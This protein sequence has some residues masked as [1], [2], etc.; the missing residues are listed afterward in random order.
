MLQDERTSGF[1]EDGFDIEPLECQ[2]MQKS[3]T[4][5]IRKMALLK[6]TF[7]ESSGAAKVTR[8]V[9]FVVIKNSSEDLLFGKPTLD[10]LG[11]VSDK[12][13]IELR[14]LGLRFATV[15]P[16]EAKGSDTGVFLRT[17][18]NEAFQAPRGNSTAHQTVQC[19]LP[20]CTKKG[21][22]WLTPGPNLP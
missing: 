14:S 11:F 12:Y 21:Q 13:T 19:V 9:G 4:F 1:V 15:L 22:W 18:C 16:D 5:T 20:T 2:S 6:V 7:Q 10:E 17:I 3:G 8:S